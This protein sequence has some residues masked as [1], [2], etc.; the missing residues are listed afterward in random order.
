MKHKFWLNKKRRK[1]ALSLALFSIAFIPTTV[2][3]LYNQP[4][5]TTQEQTNT[6]NYD[7]SNSYMVA[8]S[9]TIP[10][11]EVYGS[12]SG[13]EVPTC[14]TTTSQGMPVGEIVGIT[15]GS[16]AGVGLIV[17]LWYSYKKKQ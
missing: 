12:C 6:N 9:N 2:V 1:I 5:I 17:Y 3:T 14:T 8:S 11:I 7:E 10:S 13:D 15:I 4:T 16:I